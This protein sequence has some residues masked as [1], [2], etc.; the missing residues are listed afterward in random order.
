MTTR[1]QEGLCE[2][3]ERVE[4]LVDW[5]RSAIGAS[6]G[7]TIHLPAGD[8]SGDGSSNA[9]PTISNL[10]GK[11]GV[12]GLN[13]AATIVQTE[14]GVGVGVDTL[15]VNLAE[16]A[17]FWFHIDGTDVWRMG[18]NVEEIPAPGSPQAWLGIAPANESP[19]GTFASIF[20]LQMAQAGGAN[21]AEPIGAEYVYSGA[22]APYWGALL[23]CY[24]G[25]SIALNANG[26]T[27]DEFQAAG[28][29]IQ[30]SAGWTVEC[31]LGSWTLLC[32]GGTLATF[33]T[34]PLT[35]AATTIG[36]WGG[37]ITLNLRDGAQSGA[38]VPGPAND[39]VIYQAGASTENEVIEMVAPQGIANTQSVEGEWR[40]VM[41]VTTDGA[42]S[43][44]QALPYTPASGHAASVRA[45]F[46]CRD[47][48]N[49]HSFSR[50]LEATIA[51]IGGT[52]QVLGTGAVNST[53]D[54]TA[55]LS[56]AALNL[57]VSGGVPQITCV[58]PAAY[59]DDLDWKITI[60]ITPN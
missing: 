51:N 12:V 54:G 13:G 3:L 55:A 17:P 60:S 24:G 28:E 38:I 57:T 29:T 23:D 50:T 36:L 18:Y 25:G 10:T 20:H 56:T 22:G 40:F 15:Y 42:S 44:S 30:T 34:D 2:R 1:N 58:P 49:T 9:D 7:G 27:F 6:G 45:F 48:S 37:E 31:A 8:L 41:Y 14:T 19:P 46:N 33:S 39:R 43:A 11:S 47:L 35:I 52:V 32:A 26:T 21:A 16:A 5:L 53:G 59:A 4:W